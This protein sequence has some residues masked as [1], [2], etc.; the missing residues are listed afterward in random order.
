MIASISLI[1]DK[2]TVSL[3]FNEVGNNKIVIDLPTADGYESF[4][5]KITFKNPI[6]R[7]RNHDYTWAKIN[8]DR[9]AAEYSPKIIQLDNGYFIQPNLS[10]GIWEIEREN[11][12]VLLWRFNPR[13]ASP[14]TIY[15]GLNAEKNI[16]SANA[17]LNFPKQPELLFSKENAVEFSRS[18]LLFSAIACFTDH[19]DFDTADNVKLQREFFKTNGIKVTKGFFLKHFSKR[20]DNASFENDAV[21]FDKWREDGHELAYHSLTQSLKSK[22]GSLAD[23]MDF[24]PPFNDIPTWID[25]GYQP[26]NLSLYKNTGINEIDFSN[27]LKD[28]NISILWNYIDSGTSSSGVINQM[29]PDDFTLS[30]FYK[31]IKSLPFG[32]RMG[33][34]IKNIMF[35][36][37]ADEKLI[38]RY[39]A[40][41]TNFKQLFLEKKP[42][43]F[44]KLIGNFIT[45]G[46]PLGR[47]LL[48]W[49]H[50]K[51]RPYKLAKYSPLVFRH[52]IAEND[53]YVFQ[54][55]E[56]IDFKK[57]LSAGNIEKLINESGV[58]I[59]HTYF[60]VPMEYHTGKMFRNSNEIDSAVADNFADLGNRI[61]GGQIWN[62][63]LKEFVNFLANFE[64]TIL[65]VDA[66]G[67]IVVTNASGVPYRNTR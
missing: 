45:L 14:I 7:F 56:M 34:L 8:K 31:G 25:H 65:D 17:K 51:K 32:Q 19:C 60:S 22:E 61:A 43:A 58:F 52:R 54:T 66:D 11:P 29:N 16:K 62:P 64:K 30:G 12:K 49:N 10:K 2:K 9:I 50:H 18:K 24:K 37:Y 46:V 33:I 38:L 40:A 21:E 59:A 4:D 63:T 3:D 41:A 13:Y 27:N 53:F 6:V 42:K 1:T 57:S 55:L 35:H 39:K 5:L 28:K 47:V 48:F 36:Y 23:F 67:K 15:S 26:Y 44:F 20:E